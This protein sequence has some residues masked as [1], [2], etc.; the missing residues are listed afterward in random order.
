MKFRQ[1]IGRLYQAAKWFRRQR[2]RGVNVP[3]VPHFD[4]DLDATNFFL[5]RLAL[6]RLYLEY[7]SGGSTVTAARNRISF[8]TVDG[9]QFYLASVKRKIE[10]EFGS[11]SGQFVYVNIGLTGKWNYPYF[12]RPTR[13]R[14]R[15][16]KQ[17]AEAPWS[18]I[19][20]RKQYPDLVLIDGRFRAAC[21][22]V[23][24]R[25]LYMKTDFILMIDDYVDR[26]YTVVEKFAHLDSM[27]G[28]MAVFRCKKI[29]PV[30]I[31][32]AIE[33]ASSDYR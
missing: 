11:V 10:R 7:G 29:D 21:A 19:E 16:W 5:K 27:Q 25:H 15:K 18:I 17:Y 13:R 24:L 8:I 3:D 9:D 14:L 1:D 20:Q 4:G 23:A 32:S 2:I 12:D 22:L 31:E 26:A 6:S 28:R 30:E 33:L